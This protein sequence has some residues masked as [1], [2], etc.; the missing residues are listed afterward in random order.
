[1]TAYYII[2]DNGESV[3]WDQRTGEAIGLT[4]REDAEVWCGKED[5][6]IYSVTTEQPARRPV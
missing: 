3:L 6:G 1:M 2:D 4:S 5:P